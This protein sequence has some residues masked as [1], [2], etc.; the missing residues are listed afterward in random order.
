MG[1]IRAA[2]QAASLSKALQLADPI[3]SWALA[4]IIISTTGWA[5]A[6]SYRGLLIFAT[7]YLHM[8]EPFA[9]GY[10]IIIDWLIA[11][12][13]LRLF[14]CALREDTRWRTR[15]WAWTITTGALAASVLG[16]A[17]HDGLHASVAVKAGNAIAPLAATIA[18]GF[19]LG[20]VKDA[21]ARVK[22]AEEL[23]RL[24]KVQRPKT[25]RPKIEQ[26]SADERPAIGDGGL[27][28]IT[29]LD[30]NRP[31]RKTGPKPKL[32]TDQRLRQLVQEI[33]KEIRNGVTFTG[34]GIHETYGVSRHIATQ[35]LDAAERRAQEVASG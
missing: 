31:R 18:L 23:A 6:Q 27:P 32:E 5:F 14:R 9:A 8:P 1:R 16:N 34:R 12:G 28:K 20:L 25:G 33:S 2:A 4:V 35:V 15:G 3:S 19:G 17:V 30:P 21:V 13:E 10:P 22:E 26:L 11:M 7:T 24:A 29:V